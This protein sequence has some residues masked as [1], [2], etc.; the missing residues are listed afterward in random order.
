MRDDSH[1]TNER[2]ARAIN[3]QGHGKA[4]PV[5]FTAYEGRAGK[6]GVTKRVT[7]RR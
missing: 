7:M 2:K 6:S 3:S 4:F 1:R 5:E